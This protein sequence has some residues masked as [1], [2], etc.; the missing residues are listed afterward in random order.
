VQR[1]KRSPLVSS[2][3]L[4]RGVAAGITMLSLAGMTAYAGGHLHNT[5]APLQPAA[6]TAAPASAATTTSTT[7]TTGRLQLSRTVPTT[8]SSRAVTTTHHS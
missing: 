2:V 8:T 7:T 5:A 3:N 1:Q 6:G 4:L